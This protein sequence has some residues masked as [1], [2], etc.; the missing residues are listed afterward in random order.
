MIANPFYR[1]EK[2][3]ILLNDGQEYTLERKY[4][5]D[6]FFTEIEEVHQCL[7]NQKFESSRMSHQDSLDIIQAMEDIRKTF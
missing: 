3:T 2:A 4:I 1:P 5:Y 7:K 6:D